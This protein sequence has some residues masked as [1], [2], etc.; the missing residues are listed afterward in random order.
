M[1]Q[2]IDGSGNDSTAA[3]KAWLA[4][5]RQLLSAD[6]FQLQT[7][8]QGEPWSQNLLLTTFDRPLIWSHV[9]TF[10]PARLKRGTVESKIGLD[11]ATLDL[12]WYLRDPAGYP[13]GFVY[14]AFSG[15]ISLL[16]SFHLGLWDNGRVWLY[17]TVMPAL[18]DC[19]TFG[20]M[21]LFSGRMAEITMTRTGVKLKI[22]ALTEVFDAQVPANL[23]EPNNVQAQYGLGQPPA[24]L[25]SAPV[26]TVASGSTPAM[27][28]G[29]CVSPNAGQMFGADTFDFGYIQFNSGTSLGKI[30]RSIWV[31][32]TAYGQNMFRLYEP[33]PWMPALGEQFTAYVPYARNSNAGSG[34][35]QGFPYVPPPE[36]AT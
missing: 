30:H 1:R 26:F 12:E 3:V 27:L 9:G 13:D 4:S 15:E 32:G 8:I 7:Y 14:E 24:G 2:C 19:H 5:N 18:G 21:T 33:L 28:L 16:R 34:S 25:A 35:F 36:T 23:I 20:A 11:T 6:L 22:N 17:R 31:S 10:I 29:A